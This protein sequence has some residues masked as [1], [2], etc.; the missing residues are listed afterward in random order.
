MESM[1]SKAVEAWKSGSKRNNINMVWPLLMPAM[2]RYDESREDACEDFS[3]SSTLLDVDRN[4]TLWNMGS[5]L[6]GIEPSK[7]QSSINL[8]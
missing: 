5:T 7:F 8:K 3:L 4:R 2:S 1:L 6:I